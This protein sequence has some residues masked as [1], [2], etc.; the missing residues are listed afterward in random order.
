MLG[1][2]QTSGHAVHFQLKQVT[3]CPLL[4]FLPFLF[5]CVIRPLCLPAHLFMLEILFQF[6][7]PPSNISHPPPPLSIPLSL[8]LLYCPSAHGGL[9][10]QIILHNNME[11]LHN[12]HHLFTAVK[13]AAIK[14][15][16]SFQSVIRA[17]LPAP[18]TFWK[19]ALKREFVDSVLLCATGALQ[20]VCLQL[21]NDAN[22]SPKAAAVSCR[23]DI[24]MPWYEDPEFRRI[25]SQNF[26]HSN[27]RKCVTWFLTGQDEIPALHQNVV[28]ESGSGEFLEI[29]L[30]FTTL[31]VQMGRRR[32][33]HSDCRHKN[34]VKIW[35]KMSLSS[36]LS[37]TTPFP[38][39]QI[40][41]V[42][43]KICFSL[44]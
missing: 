18:W 43:I 21:C 6:S 44:W 17:Q 11:G 15:V 2:P 37:T 34:T 26:L 33:W 13:G 39:N 25:F 9:L 35:V 42:I 24:I 1:C 10:Q 22:G 14:M 41:P 8:S 23:P 31:S 7:T 5:S 40:A 20:I 12:K 36:Q 4:T 19:Q 32:Q 38:S 29:P 16:V 30:K 27:M 3:H 28:N